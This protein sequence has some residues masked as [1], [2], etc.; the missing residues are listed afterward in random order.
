[1]PSYRLIKH[2]VAQSGKNSP[3]PQVNEDDFV[4]TCDLFKSPSRL[5]SE[6][7]ELERCGYICRTEPGHFAPAYRA[8]HWRRIL[9]SKIL[10]YIGLSVITPILVTLL[11]MWITGALQPPA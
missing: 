6:L 5:R 3:S 2:I 9:L 1:M 7:G 10:R 8:Y 11:T 4:F